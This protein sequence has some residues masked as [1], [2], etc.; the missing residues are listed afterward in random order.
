MNLFNLV[1]SSIGVVTVLFFIFCYGVAYERANIVEKM[2]KGKPFVIKGIEMD[3][4][5]VPGEENHH[6]K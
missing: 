1:M 4:R 2:K 5:C 3:I 6:D